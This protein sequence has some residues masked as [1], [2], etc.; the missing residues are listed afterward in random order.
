[1]MAILLQ[2]L[3]FIFGALLVLLAL[4]SAIRS[5]VLP[6]SDNVFLTRIV[7]I[8]VNRLLRLRLRW[9]KTYKQR[10]HIMAFYAPITLLLL[11][12]VWLLSVLAGYMCMFWALEVGD[13]T[14]FAAFNVSGSSLLTLG[15]ATV[16]GWL[17]TGLAF[18]A[19][20]IGL[21][22]MA[23]LIA[24]LPTMYAAFSRRES[25]VKMLEVRAGSPPWSITM[26]ERLHHIHGLESAGDVWARWEI[27]FVELGESHTSL[28][29]LIFFRSPDPDKS[30]VTAAGTVLDAAALFASTLD[31]PP[32]ARAQLCL[33]A[34]YLT[35]Q[36]IADFFSFPYD[37]AQDLQVGDPDHARQI[38]ITRSEFEDACNRL[39][40]E[41]VPLKPDRDQAWRDFAGWR[42]NYDRVLLALCI[43]TM[44]PPTPWSSDRAPASID[45]TRRK[46]VEKG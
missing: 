35:L 27:W 2:V 29:P 18:S 23:L 20:M 25:L 12:V 37:H 21:G 6:R 43:T 36:S 14:V 30:W 41:G 19:A 7:F 38:S 22:L 16:D 5:L 31:V 32:D 34:G 3:T 10:D 44:A 26:I 17:Q 24:Y 13:G 33:R 4:S 46:R 1:M 45:I 11:P 8:Y 42:V 9:T 28:A 15:F 40:G 39:A